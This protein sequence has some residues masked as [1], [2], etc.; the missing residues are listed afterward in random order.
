MSIIKIFRTYIYIYIYIY[1]SHLCNLI[2]HNTPHTDYLFNIIYFN[3]FPPRCNLH[4]CF[5]RINSSYL[6]YIWYIGCG[7]QQEW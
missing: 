6:E 1:I 7:L 3:F 4:L 5:N 2:P